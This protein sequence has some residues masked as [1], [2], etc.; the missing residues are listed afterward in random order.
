MISPCHNHNF[1]WWG[2][3]S[4][5]FKIWPTVWRS[6]ETCTNTF[7]SPEAAVM[8]GCFGESWNVGSQ[9]QSTVYKYENSLGQWSSTQSNK[10][11]KPTGFSA[12]PRRGLLSPSS[13]HPLVCAHKSSDLNWTGNHYYDYYNSWLMFNIKNMKEQIIKKIFVKQGQTLAWFTGSNPG[14]HSFHSYTPETE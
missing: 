9:T 11:H 5:V 3:H 8:G 7:H 6:R 13:N 14:S 2:Y 12:L 4:L 10:A 1:P